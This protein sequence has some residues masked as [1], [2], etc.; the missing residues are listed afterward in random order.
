[1]PFVEP[2]YLQTLK[3]ISTN[4]VE[5]ESEKM[6]AINKRLAEAS[7]S[8]NTLE[9]Y[10]N[11]YLKRLADD[12]QSG[13]SSKNYINYQTFLQKLED[14]IIG[15]K[16]Q[17]Q[18]LTDELKIQMTIWQ[19]SQRTKLSYEVISNNSEKQFHQLEAKKDQKLMDEFATRS[20]RFTHQ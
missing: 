16:M 11:D 18:K 6:F 8:L 9:K 4:K 15:Q 7:D 10:R 14:A 13:L 5:I 20:T 2:Q 3:V 1:M 19:Q 17:L 12:L